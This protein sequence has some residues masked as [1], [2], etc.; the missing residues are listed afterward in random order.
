MKAINLFIYILKNRKFRTN[1]PWEQDRQMAIYNRSS[2]FIQ[3]TSHPHKSMM[4]RE[5]GQFRISDWCLSHLPKSGCFIS[6]YCANTKSKKDMME[7][8]LIEIDIETA[9]R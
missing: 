1:W 6:H 8:Y 5:P 2:S 7:E 3:I 4:P 9:F